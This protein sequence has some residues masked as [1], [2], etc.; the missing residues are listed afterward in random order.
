MALGLGQR[1]EG[2]APGLTREELG[3][4]G[5][6]VRNEPLGNLLFKAALI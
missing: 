3:E 5:W 2:R 6:E 4:L 1:P